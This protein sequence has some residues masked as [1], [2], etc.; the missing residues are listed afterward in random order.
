MCLQLCVVT[1]YSLPT[2]LVGITLGGCLE[3]LCTINSI[4]G[5][6]TVKINPTFNLLCN[7][8]EELHELLKDIHVGLDVNYGVHVFISLSVANY[9]CCHIACEK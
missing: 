6:F 2:M 4:N 1:K 9:V 3:T 5:K 8:D 7:V